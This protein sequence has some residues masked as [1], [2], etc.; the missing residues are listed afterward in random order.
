MRHPRDYRDQD[1]L[2]LGLAKSG[3]AV[4]KVFA[5]RGARV[6][7]N[8]A[9]PREACPEADELERLG[10]RVVC[11]GHPEGIVHEGIRLVVKNPGIPYRI[12]PLVKAAELGI[13]I[14]T[15]VEVAW[16]L[17]KGPMIGITGTNG[18]TTTTSWTGAMLEASG[19][20]PV[21]AGNIGRPLC[22]AAEEAE[23]GRWLVAELSSFQ[24]KGTTDFRP[25]IACLLNFSE[26]HM[27]WHG[28]MEDYWASK[29]RLFANQTEED[30]AVLNWD[31]PA[32]RDLAPRLAAR[33]IPFSASGEPEGV[34]AG[35]RRLTNG[36]VYAENG[37]IVLREPDGSRVELLPADDLGIAGR[38]NLE[39][40][41]AAAA[42]AWAAGADP[43]AIAKVLR[44]FRGVEHR[45]ELV[46][47]VAG[48]RWYNDSKATN[49]T[50]ASKAL[51]AFR[52]PIVW[53]GGGL[54]RGADFRDL[55]PWFAGKVKAAVVLGETR[56]KLAQ[57]AREAGVA[58]IRVVDAD[59]RERAAEAV[60]EA[61]R[62]AAG[63][64]RA[65]DIVLFSPACAS[66]DMFSSYEERGRMFKAAVHRL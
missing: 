49:A 61:V 16:H 45:Q 57:A 3:Q 51:D 50:A 29:I 14:V 62:L 58:I 48:V 43:A 63:E 53:I 21:V 22:D 31:D 1:V 64:A 27:D 36:C 15:E 44:T 30:A 39:N 6:T 32:C 59:S 24:L 18:K 9:K 4:A 56:H 25:K 55:M 2:V 65:G 34:A 11:G 17:A 35:E 8:D 66:W 26:T 40:G 38:H 13:E 60:E 52:E 41:L 54:D 23:P 7:V 20:R 28:T 19:L 42:A 37:N 10:V 33:V 46:R 5:A 47:E 12:P